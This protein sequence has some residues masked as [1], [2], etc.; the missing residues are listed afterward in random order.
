MPEVSDCPDITKWRNLLTEKLSSQ[1][2]QTLEDHLGNCARCVQVLET[3]AEG[4]DD[5][6]LKLELLRSPAPPVE[7][8]LE[9]VIQNVSHTR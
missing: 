7:P 8:E 5:P 1:E 9:R 6:P 2:Q 4:L 3:L